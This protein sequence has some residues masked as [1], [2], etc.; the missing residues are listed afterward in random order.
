MKVD[1]R[2]ALLAA[3]ALS[4]RWTDLNVPLTLG[5][6]FTIP[7]GLEID[8]RQMDR[9]QVEIRLLR[10]RTAIARFRLGIPFRDLIGVP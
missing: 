3:D 8:V 9:R 4:I 2:Q 5:F 10:Q 7:A 1:L 6:G